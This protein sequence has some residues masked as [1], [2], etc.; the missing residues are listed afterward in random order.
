LQFNI[1]AP[2]PGK[3]AAKTAVAVAAVA[4]P[5]KAA[6]NDDDAGTLE[7]EQEL[8]S[9]D[10]SAAP[11]AKGDRTRCKATH[12]DAGAE[13]DGEPFS[14]KHAAQGFRIW[15]HGTMKQVRARKGKEQ[16]CKA[17]FD[18]DKTQTKTW[19]SRLE[20]EPDENDSVSSSSDDT[21][22]LKVLGLDTDNDDTETVDEIVVPGG[23]IRNDNDAD[24]GAASKKRRCP[25]RA[26]NTK[27]M[28]PPTQKQ[29]P[30]KS[31]ATKDQQKNNEE[32]LK[33]KGKSKK[34]ANGE[35]KTTE[36]ASEHDDDNTNGACPCNQPF[37]ISF[38]LS[39][40]SLIA[41]VLFYN[42][43]LEF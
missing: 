26:T 10:I 38:T 15:V 22:A 21:G 16:T 5:K 24:V 19:H 12:F 42:C 2:T 4:E 20:A 35:D 3:A 14:V 32:K 11:F 36:V 29:I 25:A 33:P 31:V 13:L 37:T 7:K 43:N 40:V 27:P 41:I 30:K 8:P 9:P 17:P 6:D 18:G 1:P 34:Q 28:P 23:D 39:F